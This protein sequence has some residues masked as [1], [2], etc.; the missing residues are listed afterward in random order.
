[1]PNADQGLG[2]RAFAP[3]TTMARKSAYMDN[4]IHTGP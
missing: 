4:R 2:I 1:L 3:S